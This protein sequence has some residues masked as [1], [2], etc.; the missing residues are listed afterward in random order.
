M[1]SKAQGKSVLG[2]MNSVQSSTEWFIEPMSVPLLHQSTVIAINTACFN[3]W[4]RDNRL[5]NN[6]RTYLT[7]NMKLCTRMTKQLMLY[8]DIMGQRET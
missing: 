7:V 4:K 8:G 6:I 1:S 5:Y 2:Q 3:I